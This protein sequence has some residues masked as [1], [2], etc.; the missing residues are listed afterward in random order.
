MWYL[1]DCMFPNPLCTLAN[2]R[3]G[4]LR[5]PEQKNG[6]FMGATLQSTGSYFM[7]CVCSLVP[8]LSTPH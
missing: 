5:D 6:Q 3:L 2:D 1:N 4:D 8:R 7:V